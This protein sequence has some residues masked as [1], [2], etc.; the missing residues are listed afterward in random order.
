MK[1]TLAL[2]HLVFICLWLRVLVLVRRE[3]LCCL[4][5]VKHRK[6][7]LFFFLF[8]IPFRCIFCWILF[9]HFLS[10]LKITWMHGIFERVLMIF[11][12][13]HFLSVY[14]LIFVCFSIFSFQLQSKSMLNVVN[15]INGRKKN[16]NNHRIW[17]Y[18]S[19]C[20]CHHCDFF[21]ALFPAG[22]V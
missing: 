16:P 17:A 8:S 22:R 15:G 4:W 3:W 1:I 7:A 13:T 11:S 2:V 12:R 18:E 9:T 6:A 20:Y 14:I 19:S 21:F 5:Q 10:Y